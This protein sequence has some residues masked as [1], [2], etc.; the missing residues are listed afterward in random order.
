[1]KLSRMVFGALLLF[2]MIASGD[3]TGSV[4]EWSASLPS[5]VDVG[6]D[7]SITVTSESDDGVTVT[8]AEVV[9][10]DVTDRYLVAGRVKHRE[11]AGE[12]YLEM[13]S[14]FEEGRYFTRTNLDAGPLSSMSGTSDWR[15][16]AL[17][18]DATDAGAPPERL[19][20]NVVLPGRG[21]ITVSAMTLS[22]LEA[23]DWPVQAG[24]GGWGLWSGVA[25]AVLG[26][27]AGILS[28]LGSKGYARPLVLRG[29]LALKV[30]GGLSLGLGG[31]FLVSGAPYRVFFPLMLLGGIAF[32]VAWQNLPR[33][34]KRYEELELRR[35][36]ALDA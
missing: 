3:E 13:W 22:G 1:M 25:G 19:T 31:V 9:S 12:A 4:V 17:P 10:P 33:F 14:A 30:L 26:L 27:I 24:G 21:Q 29:F 16:I 2:S 20:L 23:G 18:F 36:S 11:V 35:L 8:V 15:E 6:E 34:T 28:W 7:G 5:N 32:M